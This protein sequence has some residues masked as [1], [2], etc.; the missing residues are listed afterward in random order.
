[1]RITYSN[2]STNIPFLDLNIHHE[3]EKICFKVYEKT[4]SIHAYLTPDTAHPLP[5][6]KGF[7]LGE[8]IR[9][10]RICTFDTDFIAIRKLLFMRLQAR[11]YSPIWLYTFMFKPVSRNPPMKV[12]GN[13]CTV[14]PLRFTRSTAY[15]NIRK[16]LRELETLIQ[17][18][19]NE[20]TTLMLSFS[21]SPKLAKL[22][23]RSDL[24]REQLAFLD[25]NG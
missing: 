25:E 21:Q 16:E 8:V 2:S 4:L 15:P 24:T 6:L 23:L 17:S 1:M 20:Q 18:E 22:C 7:I 5:T 12:Q 10:R 14:L 13:S 19:I 9:Y 3:D 11:G